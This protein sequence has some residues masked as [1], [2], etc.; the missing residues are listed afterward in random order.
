MPS[1]PSPSPA[2]FDE[3]ASP[4]KISRHQGQQGGVRGVGESRSGAEADVVRVGSA[5]LLEP[6]VDGGVAD[7][8]LL[9]EVLAL[10]TIFLI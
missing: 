4:Y 5:E 10:R 2:V 9:G 7:E 1:L 3:A 8:V 6:R